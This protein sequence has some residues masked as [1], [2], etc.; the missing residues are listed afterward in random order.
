MVP[1][2]GWT[3]ADWQMKTMMNAPESGALEV[4][5]FHG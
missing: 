3:I 1:G 2:R 5:R 4:T